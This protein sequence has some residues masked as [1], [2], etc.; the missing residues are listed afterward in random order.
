MNREEG[1]SFRNSS[2]VRDSKVFAV[3][4]EG[5][6]SL[7]YSSIFISCCAFF[8][9]VETFLLAGI[10]VSLPLASFVFL[11]TLFTYNLSSIQTVLRGSRNHKKSASWAQRHK[12][13]L[14]FTGTCSL[15]GA[16]LLYWLYQLHINIWFM[17]HLAVIS[18]GYTI[19]IIY[20]SKKVRP[21][22]SVPL[23]KVFL[24]AY[25]WAAV[26][27]FFPLLHAKVA[28]WEQ[29]VLLL[30]LR[31]FLFILA[32]A[33]LF[34][35]RD[36]LYDQTTNTLTVPGFVGVW[37]TKLLSLGLLLLNGLIGIKMENMPLGIA[38]LVAAVLSALVVL[39][40]SEH[41]PRVYYAILA[42]GAM[43]LHAGLVYLATL[44]T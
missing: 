8:L 42:D 26:T 21:L 5:L 34:D 29:E 13:E 27:V 25:V 37:N 40:S 24:I 3:L 32:L 14:A 39:Y 22:R 6:Y 10:P 30:F 9:T 44:Y 16:I 17:L 18:V 41:K 12:Q 38:L 7:L 2:Q 31:R 11:A 20:K 36:Y 19:P 4:A 28:M 33:L 23:L 43:L 35:I 15:L 1:V